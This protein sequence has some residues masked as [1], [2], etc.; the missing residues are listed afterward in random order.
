MDQSS[1]ELRTQLAA[2]LS[3]LRQINEQLRRCDSSV[4]AVTLRLELGHLQRTLS[5]LSEIL[6]I[7]VNHL[8]TLDITPV[9]P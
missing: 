1:S 5:A 8:P 3:E 4:A 7:V 9:K 6:M 2:L